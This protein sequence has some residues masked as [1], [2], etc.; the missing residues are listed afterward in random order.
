MSIAASFPEQDPEHLSRTLDG[1]R[2]QSEALVDDLG[3]FIPVVETMELVERS[4]LATEVPDHFKAITCTVPNVFNWSFVGEKVLQRLGSDSVIVGVEGDRDGKIVIPTDV[5]VYASKR[6]TRD[7]FYGLIEADEY[8]GFDLLQKIETTSYIPGAYNLDESN[9][10]SWV[11]SKRLAPLLETNLLERAF[12]LNVL[13]GAMH[14]LRRPETQRYMSG[15]LRE[16]VDS[17]M[18]M[19]QKLAANG[20]SP[21]G[22]EEVYGMM[23]SA[24]T[25]Y[26]DRNPD[27]DIRPKREEV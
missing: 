12:M 9:R 14:Q 22:L 4:L 17:G 26:M 2:V 5:A 18:G 10:M 7:A 8:P 20:V 25:E 16:S 23:Y 21:L 19:Y 11:N 24:M 3:T 15:M 6:L 1:F 13:L 27:S